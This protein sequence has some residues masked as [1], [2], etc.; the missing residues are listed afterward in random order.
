M[1]G[2]L[3]NAHFKEGQFVKRGDLLFQIDPR[4]FQTA[5][6]QARAILARDTPVIY[7]YLDRWA[8]RFDFSFKRNTPE[9]VP[10]E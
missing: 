2:V 6:D 5:L 1:Q 7:I 9:L 4:G 10:A 8:Q 3:E